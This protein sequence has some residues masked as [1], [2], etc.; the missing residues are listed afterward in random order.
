MESNQMKLVVLQLVEEYLTSK[1]IFITKINI[2]KNPL[3]PVVGVR[4]ILKFEIEYVPRLDFY[5][6]EKFELEEDKEGGEEE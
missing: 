3:L 1:D 2:D 5:E 4:N 6:V